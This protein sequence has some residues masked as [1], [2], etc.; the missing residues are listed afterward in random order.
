MTRFSFAGPP[1]TFENC[2]RHPVTTTVGVL[3]IAFTAVWCFEAPMEWAFLDHNLGRGEIWRIITCG[4]LHSGILHL[5]FN[6][7]WLW[8]FGVAVEGK[9]GSYKTTG[10]FVFLLATSSLAQFALDIGGVGLSGL[11]YG[12]WTLVWCAGRGVEDM[13]GIATREV[14]FLFIIWFFLCLYF[15]ESEILIVGNTAHLAGAVTGASAGLGIAMKGLWRALFT[16]L[17]IVAAV[18]SISGATFL[19]ATVNPVEAGTDLE[20]LAY[21]AYK[22]NDNSRAIELYEQSLSVSPSAERWLSLGELYYRRGDFLMAVDALEEAIQLAGESSTASETLSS[23]YAREAYAVN[24]RGETQEA[25]ALYRKS[26]QYN[27][28]SSHSWFNLGIILHKKGQLE[29]AK[30]SYKKACELEPNNA[31]YRGNLESLP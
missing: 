23:I 16:G 22:A 12:L 13:R 30:A 31:A 14:N 17:C 27:P 19:R 7:Y 4:F 25:E 15:T 6:V 21:E 1:L 28:R 29:E 11:V 18:A 3:A 9:W 20:R 10:L 5:V 8:L 2:Q 24:E 26:L